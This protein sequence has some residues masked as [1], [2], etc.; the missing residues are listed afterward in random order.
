[1][2]ISGPEKRGVFS[3]SAGKLVSLFLRFSEF[4]GLSP[5]TISFYRQKLQSFL[6]FHEALPIEK[7]NIL[8]F[9]SYLQGAGEF[10]G[11]HKHSFKGAQGLFPLG[12][13]PGLYPFKSHA[14]DSHDEV[15]AP[16]SGVLDHL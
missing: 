13:F 16:L 3:T 15:P 1:M 10:P 6:E 8:E 11:D 5:Q 7:E 9:I 14:G 2:R 12:A 4:K